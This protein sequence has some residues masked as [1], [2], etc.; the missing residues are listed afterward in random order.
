MSFFESNPLVYGLWAVYAL[1]ATIYVISYIVWAVKCSTWYEKIE[2]EVPRTARRVAS[3]VIKASTFINF[4]FYA[5]IVIFAIAIMV[6]IIAVENQHVFQILVII[7][8]PWVLTGICKFVIGR[9]AVK[10]D[11]HPSVLLPRRMGITATSR[12]ETYDLGMI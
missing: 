7:A 4:I 2:G 8:A 5:T 11:L 9:R 12:K 10:R 6:N 3:R 1:V